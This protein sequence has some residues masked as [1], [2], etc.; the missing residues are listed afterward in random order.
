MGR[1]GRAGLRMVGEVRRRGD[2]GRRLRRAGFGGVARRGAVGRGVGG[3][4]GCGA[5]RAGR[6]GG[7]VGGRSGSGGDGHPA[8]T[9]PESDGSL[10]GPAVRR[11]PR[12]EAGHMSAPDH[13]LRRG[14]SSRC[15]RRGVHTCPPEPAHT[16]LS[17]RTSLPA[18][19]SLFKLLLGREANG[20]HY[21]SQS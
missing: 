8:V 19:S 15:I 9:R 16:F 12:A 11:T 3:D 21:S 2:G 18:A 6:S 17:W 5:C 4:G 1:W 20:N 13:Q 10:C 14:T 7:P